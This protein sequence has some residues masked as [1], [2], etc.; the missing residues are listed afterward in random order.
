MPLTISVLSNTRYNVPKYGIH[1]L[2]D[3]LA[4]VVL[5]AVHE[6]ETCLCSRNSVGRVAA[7]THEYCTAMR[8]V[9]G[10][11]TVSHAR[12][13][14]ANVSIVI[15]SSVRSERECGGV[16]GQTTSVKNN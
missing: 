12:G 2:N 6:G 13:G 3:Q 1:D 15:A 7:C 16:G 9:V 5:I 14:P 10:G 8:C 11:Q 4:Y